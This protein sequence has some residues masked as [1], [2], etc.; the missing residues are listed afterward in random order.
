MYV[1]E[2]RLQGRVLAIQ[3]STEEPNRPKLVQRNNEECEKFLFEKEKE[4]YVITVAREDST[5]LQ[6]DESD[7]SVIENDYEEKA[8][9]KWKVLPREA[10]S[11]WV[12][13]VCC[14][15]N[16]VLT[17]RQGEHGSE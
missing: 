2:S 16:K 8:C 17:V 3:P 1:L 7:G 12:A 10:G 15:T 9:N 13:L 5:V 4:E 11:S 14:K 6:V